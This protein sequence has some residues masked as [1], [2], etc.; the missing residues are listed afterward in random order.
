MPIL[1]AYGTTYPVISDVFNSARVIMN[2]TFKGKT[3]T[4][5]EGRIFTNDWTPSIT[6]LNL[7]LQALQ[8]DLENSGYH[9]TTEEIFYASVPAIA[10]P[11]GS[12]VCDPTVQV[13]M[14][15]NGFFDG[16]ILHDLATDPALPLDFILPIWV[17]E[18]ATG[19][20]AQFHEIMP[21]K[22]GLPSLYQTTSMGEWEWR[23]DALYF[24]GSVIPIDLR[25]RYR[26][27]MLPQFPTTLNPSS[28]ATAYIPFPDCCDVV[29]YRIAY[30]FTSARSEEKAESLLA[31]YQDGLNKIA[32]RQTRSDQQTRYSREPYG[33]EGDAFGW[34]PG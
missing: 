5:G 13:Y 25:V 2:D 1:K 29:A 28:F 12:S 26:S 21:A 7:A 10:G 18:R 4:F 22:N 11:L 17:Q 3:G 32:N 24:N 9:T 34:G 6:H 8:R 15:W 27:N 23:G 16:T 30:I 20:L 31:G 14:D 33:N 19:S